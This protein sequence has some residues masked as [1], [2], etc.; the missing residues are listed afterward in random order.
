MLFNRL[1]SGRNSEVAYV[2]YGRFS[3]ETIALWVV[4]AAIVF[5]LPLPYDRGIV[6]LTVIYAI[7]GIGVN[8]LSGYV[9]IISVGHAL[10]LAIGAYAWARLSPQSQPLAILVGLLAG[11]V[12]AAAIGWAFLRLRGYF[13]T[14]ATLA[15]GQATFVGARIWVD[16]TGGNNGLSGIPSVSIPIVPPDSAV[17]VASIFVLGLVFW[18]HAVLGRIPP[19]LAM[20]AVRGNEEAAAAIGIRIRLTRTVAF[21]ISAI[22]VVIAGAL[23]AQHTSYISPDSFTIIASV[24]LMAI[25]VIGGRGWRWAPILGALFVVALPE[26]ARFAGAYRLI[27]YGGIL[28]VVALFAPGGLQQVLTI[29]RGFWN[30]L[31][32]KASA[33]FLG[34]GRRSG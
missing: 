7:A 25:V 5:A 32:A 6:T 21:V 28:T 8:V 22:P 12:I 19:G 4:C 2:G 23:L 15:I 33:P 17:L 34:S 26:Y 29:L 1:A 30:A 27:F 3:I 9:G 13:L 14:I 20:F 18:L 31:W 24:N 11:T 10:F 16:F